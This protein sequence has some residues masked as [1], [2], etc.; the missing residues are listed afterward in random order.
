MDLSASAQVPR[1]NPF[2][3]P[4]STTFRFVL[5]IVAILGASAFIYN[6]LFFIYNAQ[7]TLDA[8]RQ[9]QETAIAAYPTDSEA[10]STAF[11]ECKAPI[12]RSEALW[13]LAGMALLVL[14]AGIIF[15]GLPTWKIWRNRLEF[16]SHEDAPEITAYLV[17]LCREMELAHTPVFLCAPFNGTAGGLV[18]GR[19]GRYYMVL[20]GGLVTQ[21]YK[22]LG[23]FRTV[24]LHELAH[25]RNADVN[26]TYFSVAIWQAFVVAALFPFAV[27][28]IFRPPGIGLA[29]PAYYINLILRMIALTVLIYLTYKALLRVREMYADVRASIYDGPTGNL[30]RI[31]ATLQRH[32]VPRWRR[33]LQAHPNPDERRQVLTDT[34]GLFRLG[35]WETFGTGVIGTIAFSNV[36]FLLSYLAAG[37]QSSLWGLS[38]GEFAA[39][40]AAL[41]FM[42]MVAGVVVAGIW[43]EHFAALVRN[44]A[45]RGV[46]R[47]AFALT[48]GAVLGIFLSIDKALDSGLTTTTSAYGFNVV[49]VAVLLLYLLFVVHWI[50]NVA[51]ARLEAA[52]S[53]PAMR[54]V[55]TAIV[56]AS[57]LLLTLIGPI[58]LSYALGLPFA[59]QGDTALALLIGLLGGFMVER[60]LPFHDYNLCQSMGLPVG[61]RAVAKIF[62]CNCRRVLGVSGAVTIRPEVA[63]A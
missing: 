45:P 44:A 42:S 37:T 4:S 31:L 32:H 48:A 35:F 59:Q 52:I 20:N 1:L 57:A 15:L 62:S 54:Q 13:T 3:F 43:K 16:I 17:Q 46:S 10:Q 22:D 12:D 19:L 26:K 5:L 63:R 58:Y 38:G 39:Y 8:L 25:L 53:A 7:S 60:D 61:W 34:S 41:I 23:L 47:L 24:V 30:D 55:Y 40:G 27:S 6:S 33:L 9:C 36:Y 14:V 49:W 50:A 56:F 18:F 21:F 2:A 29:D 51:S 28:L 11:N